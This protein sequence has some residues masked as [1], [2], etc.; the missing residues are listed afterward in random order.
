MELQHTCTD[1]AAITVQAICEDGSVGTSDI[2]LLVAAVAVLVALG[3]AVW[4]W[5]HRR[6]QE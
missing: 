4:N 3:W 6:F 2:F 5:S 1:E